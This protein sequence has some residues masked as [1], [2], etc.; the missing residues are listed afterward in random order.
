[1]KQNRRN[2]LKNTGL[3]IGGALILP[4][5]YHKS[6]PFRFFTQKEADCL[7]AICECIIPADDAPGATDAGVIYYIDKQV[8]GFFKKSKNLY[9]EGI[10]SLQKDCNKLF[11]SDFELLEN[12][13][14]VEYLQ[15]I[16]NNAAPMDSWTTVKPSDFFN[17]VISHTMQGFYGAPRHGGNK[18]YVSYR[19]LGIGYPFV[20][21]QNRYGKEDFHE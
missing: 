8:M 2:F 10:A 21:G 17:M 4:A 6:A 20:I 16:E 5:C 13:K 3:V 7:I 19:M 15:S 12:E 1:M 18:D 9:R 14:Q 11:G